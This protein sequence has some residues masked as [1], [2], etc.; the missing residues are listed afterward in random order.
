MRIFMGLTEI[1]GYYT[2]LRKGFAELGV[3]SMFVNLDKNPFRYG[4]DQDEPWLVR[5]TRRAAERRFA[6][7]RTN[8]PA[9]LWWLTVHFVSYGALFLWAVL[10]YDVFV[11][12]FFSTFFNFRELPVLKMLGKRIVYVFHGS[13][14]RPHYLN[15]FG[16]DTFP[17]ATLVELTR[18]QKRQ[19]RI[20]EQYA[21]L[22]ISNPMSSQLH[23]KPFLTF[24]A[25]GLPFVHAAPLPAAAHVRRDSAVRILHAPSNPK[26]KGTAEIHDVIRRLTGKGYRIEFI[27]ITGQPFI[28]VLEQLS[29]CDFVVDQLYSDTPM[30]GFAR[31]AAF[32]GKAISSAR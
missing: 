26:G 2:H 16:S 9:K 6:T 20:V 19:L 13:D 17:A 24:Q 32:F 12:G 15:G 1:A 28:G 5:L 14:S 30:A 10:R 25:I 4:Q 8:L 21:D 22:I 7:R 27:E 11:F 18:E 3:D 31:E 29:Q 23:E